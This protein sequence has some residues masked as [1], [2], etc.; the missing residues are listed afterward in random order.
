MDT[1]KI[2]TQGDALTSFNSWGVVTL[3]SGKR[4]NAQFTSRHGIS[5]DEMWEDFVNYKNFL[6]LCDTFGIEFWAGKGSDTNGTNGATAATVPSPQTTTQENSQTP[7][8]PEKPK[9]DYTKPVP[10][11]ELPPELNGTT[12]PVFVQDFDAI[13]ILPQLDEKATVKFFKDGLQWA[14]GAPINKWKH[15]QVA[16]ALEALGEIDPTKPAK[17][18]VA[19][20]QYWVE[21]NIYKDQ[22]GVERRYKNLKLVQATL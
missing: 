22:Q 20:E 3:K 4:V 16:K 2:Q 15:E 1:E 8:S 11:N 13:E 14:V 18:R 21:G 7:P 17:I 9:R 5:A 19:G 10:E 6:E 12:V